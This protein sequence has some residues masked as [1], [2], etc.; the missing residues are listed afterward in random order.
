[1]DLDGY[2]FTPGVFELYVQSDLLLECQGIVW[3]AGDLAEN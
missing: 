3:V 1:M 2:L